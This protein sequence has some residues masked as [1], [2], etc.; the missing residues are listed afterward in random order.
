MARERAELRTVDHGLRMLDSDPDRERFWR[1]GDARVQQH[2]V[3]V[4]RA[5]ADGKHERRAFDLLPARPAR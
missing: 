2:A 3:G 1:D 4:P 5:L